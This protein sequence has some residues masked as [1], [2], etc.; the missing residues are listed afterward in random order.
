MTTAY[1]CDIPLFKTALEKLGAKAALGHDCRHHG[2]FMTSTA[3]ESGERFIHMLNLDGFDKELY[4]YEN[5]QKLLGGR[6]IVLQSKD[7]VMLP[8]NVTI[9]GIK[10][11]YSTAEIAIVESGAIEFRLTQSEDVI[12]LETVRNILPSED[13]EVRTEGRTSLVISRKH[14]KVDDRLT[15]RFQ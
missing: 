1:A 7:G 8:L 3:S 6:K 5:G 14:G 12:A 10:I 9:E 2:I 4:L 11:V 15:V 13:Y